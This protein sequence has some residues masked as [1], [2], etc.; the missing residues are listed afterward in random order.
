MTIRLL[1]A[2]VMAAASLAGMVG[3]DG[4]GASA[5]TASAHAAP[6]PGA[7]GTT[8]GTTRTGVNTPVAI[9]V[10]RGTVNCATAMRVEQ[11][12]AAAVRN[13]KVVGN[14]GGAPVAVDGWSCES[15]PTPEVLRTGRASE[16]HTSS[17]EVLAVVVLPSPSTA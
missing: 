8:C 12:Y 7:V 13:G 1:A 16:C 11:G 10:I 5:R 6:P 2:G 3:L 4:C 9:K 17:G 15:Y 14:G